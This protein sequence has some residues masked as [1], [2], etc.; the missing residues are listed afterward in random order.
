VLTGPSRTEIEI[1]PDALIASPT[2]YAVIEAKRNGTGTFGCQQIAREL[3]HTLVVAPPRSAL[4]L[5]ILHR[6]PPVRV[7]GRGVLSLAD[8][9]SVGLDDVLAVLQTEGHSLT[10][11]DVLD[12]T[13]ESLAWITWPMMRTALT[14]AIDTVPETD[15]SCVASV[16]R[17]ARAA[18]RAI[19]WH[20]H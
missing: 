4:L 5:L 19:D 11:D 17:I 2:T 14:A 12:R 9:I 15:S 18:I 3:A 13:P 16:Q 1:Q 20:A 7:L 8:A 10:R 6:P